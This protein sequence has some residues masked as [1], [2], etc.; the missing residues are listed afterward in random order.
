MHSELH[1]M[2]HNPRQRGGAVQP[3]QPAM[4][5]TDPCSRP[6]HRPLAKALNRHL[7][8]LAIACFLHLADVDM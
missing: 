4:K 6:R 2:M 7:V 5:C 1:A 3:A 8:T